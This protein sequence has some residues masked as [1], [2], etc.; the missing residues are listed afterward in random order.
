MTAEM[1]RAFGGQPNERMQLTWLTGAPI[2]PAS[3]HRCAVGQGGLGSPATQLMRAVSW[4][5]NT[6]VSSLGGGESASRCRADSGRQPAG[7][8]SKLGSAKCGWLAQ[9]RSA[10]GVSSHTGCR[11]SWS[12]S[13]VV[14]WRAGRWPKRM[15]PALTQPSAGLSLVHGPAVCPMSRGGQ[16][17]GAGD[18]GNQAKGRG[19]R[20]RVAVQRGPFE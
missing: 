14:R 7:F 10:Q 4:H 18:H 20:S 6:G 3:V 15:S 13:R 9:I 16:L 8:V 2:R 5:D 12:A 11:R 17:A 19:A 1:R